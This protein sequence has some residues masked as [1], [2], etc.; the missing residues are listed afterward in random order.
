MFQ[1]FNFICFFIITIPTLLTQKFIDNKYYT[2]MYNKRILL[3][4]GISTK[5][6]NI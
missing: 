3:S 5:P 1:L 2:E 4:D 6:L